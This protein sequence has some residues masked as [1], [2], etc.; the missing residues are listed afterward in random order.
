MIALTL[1]VANALSSINY[2]SSLVDALSRS[3]NKKLESLHDTLA[4]F[5]L[6]NYFIIIFHGTV[7]NF[8]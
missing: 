8:N 4:H 6:H 7:S 5:V 2:F 3:K 1:D